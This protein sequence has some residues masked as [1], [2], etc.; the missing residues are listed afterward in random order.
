MNVLICEDDAILALNL[1]V[2]VEDLGHDVC[3]VC[4][5]AAECLSLIAS[6]PL[7]V[8]TVDMNLRDGRTGPRIL[9]ELAMRKIPAVIVSSERCDAT[10]LGAVAALDK[11]CDGTALEPALARAIS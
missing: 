2:T 7:D 11:P 1:E 8:V 3:G 5:S 6:L 10:A 9:K 4:R